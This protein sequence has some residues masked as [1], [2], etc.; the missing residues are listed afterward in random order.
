MIYKE[1]PTIL[2]PEK[3]EIIGE[4]LSFLAYTL[5]VFFVL[6]FS[7]VLINRAIELSLDKLLYL[8]E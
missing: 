7:F 5:N 1:Y 6:S 8:R 2:I 3:S 4:E